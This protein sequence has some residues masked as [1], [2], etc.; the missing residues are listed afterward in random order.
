MLAAWYPDITGTV[1]D[2]FDYDAWGNTVKSTGSTP[3]AY[4]Y[5]GEPFDADLG[6]YYLRARYFNPVTGR[7]LTRDPYESCGCATCGCSCGKDPSVLHKYL[8]GA[9]NP[10]NR[11]DPTGRNTQVE[12]ALLIGSITLSTV[13][14]AVDYEQRT[15][16]SGQSNGC[17]RLSNPS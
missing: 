17:K 13:A 11:I 6:L 9:A 2:T 12:N 7:F 10:I 15:H 14:V 3:S 4:L 8:Y 5:R 1:T 16:D